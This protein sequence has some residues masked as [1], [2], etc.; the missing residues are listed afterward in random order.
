[1]RAADA[2]APLIQTAEDAGAL[3][4]IE[5]IVGGL[6]Q[7][8]A[9][10]AAEAMAHSVRQ[11]SAD[12]SELR[13]QQFDEML[14]TSGLLVS[15]FGLIA[16]LWGQNRVVERMHRH[17]VAAAKQYEF[18]ASHD[19]LTGMPNR[20]SFSKT[21]SR[22]FANRLRAGGEIALLTFDLDQFKTINDTLGHAA[23][24]QMLISVAD[25]LQRVAAAQPRVTA[26]R[27]GGDEFSILVEGEA[28]GSRAPPTSRRTR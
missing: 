12:M 9:R 16:L 27:L 18:L 4:K 13:S 10:L 1:M 15:A 21:L 7:P 6:S 20:A 17:Q 2:L 22:A 19:P 3:P 11:S 23:G 8:L 5:N 26:A 28:R 25:R 24:D 14:L